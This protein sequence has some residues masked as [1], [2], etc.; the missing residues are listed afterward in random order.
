MKRQT[1]PSLQRPSVRGSRASK[2]NLI[3]QTLYYNRQLDLEL[4]TD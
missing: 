1:Y 4:D 2:K 3:M